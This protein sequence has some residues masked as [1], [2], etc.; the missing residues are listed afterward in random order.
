VAEK[1]KGG[2]T[3]KSGPGQLCPTPYR[4]C[5]HSSSPA[6]IK[7]GGPPAIGQNSGFWKQP[8]I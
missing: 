3:K 5:F 2:P 1:S 8:A 7:T 4:V 6:W